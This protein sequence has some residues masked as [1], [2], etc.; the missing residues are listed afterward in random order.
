LEFLS[1]DTA[2][3]FSGG[4]VSNLGLEYDYLDRV[5]VIFSKYLQANAGIRP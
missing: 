2:G 5:F 3:S 1:V 4:W